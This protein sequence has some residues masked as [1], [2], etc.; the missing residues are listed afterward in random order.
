MSGGSAH[1]GDHAAWRAERTAY[2]TSPTGNLALVA[3]QPVTCADPV[4]IEE[5]IPATV[6]L[7]ADQDGR[8]GVLVS[9]TA[10][11][12]VTVDGTPVAGPT[13]VERLR[14]DGTPIVRWGTKSF[15][16]FSLDGSD[17]E[18]RIY[19][20]ASEGLADF[21]EI[22]C[23]PPDP[24]LVLPATY[25]RYA[26]TGDVPWDFTRSTDS[27]HLKKVPGVVRV[28][29][30]GVAYELL[31][32]ADSGLLVIV[33]ADGTT[34]SESYAPG[35]FLK[36]PLPDAGGA[37][38][39]DFNRAFIPPCG[40]SDFYSCPVPPPQNRIAAP[41]RAGEKRVRFRSDRGH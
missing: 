30:D 38:T 19:D 33:F 36:L 25:E 20:S 24:K 28:S 4:P 3:Y 40:F 26:E 21:E 37:L 31:A 34:G 5:G 15:G 9:A 10:E 32:F 27:G 23:Y 22:E 16:V 12:G 17:V 6:A 13:F 7:V 39:L 41:I 29:V 11:A 1:G 18:L 35:R 2:V 8:E 14:A